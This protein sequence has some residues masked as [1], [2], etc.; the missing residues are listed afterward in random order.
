MMD[1][2]VSAIVYTI[3]AF[4]ET[5]F[6]LNIGISGVSVGSFMIA[7]AIL[8]IVIRLIFSVISTARPSDIE[9]VVN[10]RGD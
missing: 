1:D 9:K 4:V 2:L 8:S 7:V 6:S 10:R 3:S 5:F